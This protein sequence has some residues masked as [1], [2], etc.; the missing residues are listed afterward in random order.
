[1]LLADVYP[2]YTWLPWKFTAIPRNYWE[3][4]QNQRKSVDWAAAQLNIKEMSDWYK[5]TNAVTLPLI[6]VLIFLAIL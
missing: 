5:I 3:N 6:T 1:M 2:D 4:I